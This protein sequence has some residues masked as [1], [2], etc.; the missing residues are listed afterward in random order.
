MITGLRWFV[1]K[2][3]VIIWSVLSIKCLWLI[4]LEKKVFHVRIG[5]KR[6]IKMNVFD[7]YAPDIKYVQYYKNTCVLSIMDCVLFGVNEHVE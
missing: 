2:R 4:V 5:N 7:P 3:K 6:N 1:N